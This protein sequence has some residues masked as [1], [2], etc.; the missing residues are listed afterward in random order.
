MNRFKTFVQAG[1]MVLVA[2]VP[3][4]AADLLKYTYKPSD[5]VADPK[6]EIG[7]G[8]YLR[9]DAGWSR[10]RGGQL[11]PDIAT[12]LIQNAWQLDVGV[13][14]KFNTWFRTDLTFG[15]HKMQN[16]NQAGP[17]VTCPYQLTAIS[18]P[19]TVSTTA[20]TTATTTSSSGPTTTTTTSTNTV[21]TPVGYLWDS[22]RQTCSPAQ[23]GTSRQQD[24][25]LNGYLDL[26]TWGGITPY[27]GVGVGVANSSTKGSLQ[28]YK[29]SDNTLYNADLTPGGLNII[30][31]GGTNVSSSTSPAV[32]SNIQNASSAPQVWV[33]GNGNLIVPQPTVAF[34]KQDWTRR[35]TSASYK[36]AWS[37][38]AG[39]AIDL[40]SRAKLDIGYRFANLGK[41]TS[42]VSP[43]TGATVTTNL[44]SQEVRVGFRYMVD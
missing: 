9:G 29:T 8:W 28:Y 42:V 21:Q 33:D 15:F 11:N 17:A 4:G 22:L 18:A 39:V 14:Y 38:M 41:F 26:G 16:Y 10:D 13:G 43:V 2:S 25:M 1:L 30:V 7:T 12:K 31:A 20:T 23:S 34:A 37:L 36:F 32:V 6:V 35:I 19:T 3:G 40:T 5:E 24:A 44:T 27:V